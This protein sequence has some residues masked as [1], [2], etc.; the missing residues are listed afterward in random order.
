MKY[1][2]HPTT[3]P[4]FGTLWFEPERNQLGRKRLNLLVLLQDSRAMDRTSASATCRKRRNNRGRSTSRRAA[5][6]GR[7]SLSA[8]TPAARC[9]VNLP[10]FVSPEPLLLRVQRS[11][12]TE[13]KWARSPAL[14]C[15]PC[16]AKVATSAWATSAARLASPAMKSP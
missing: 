4:Q 9:I 2:C 16:P 7:K 6:L 12:L 11:N 13:R 15:C 3:L 1:G 5:M 10:D 8:S 14:L